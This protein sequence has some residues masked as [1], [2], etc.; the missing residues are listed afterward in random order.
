MTIVLV[1]GNPETD[2]IWRPMLRELG[3][4][5]VIC[6][7]PPGFGAPVPDRFGA[8]WI[9]YRNWLI[10]ELEQIGH[11]VHLVGHDVGGGHAMNTA[12]A[13]PD[14]LLSWTIDVMGAY[15][16]DY[17]WHDLAQLWRTINVGEEAILEWLGGTVDDR[18]QANLSLGITEDVAR[19]LAVGQDQTMIRSLL[20]LYRSWPE[21]M[22]KELAVNLPD[23]SVV[24]GLV[25]I[26][27]GDDYVG[28]VEM[29]RR[30]AERAGAT[31]VVELPHGHWWMLENPTLAAETLTNFW[32][33]VPTAGAHV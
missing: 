5:D 28:N 11:P 3:R 27:T 18:V 14:L 29:R 9:E 6:L 21:A 13:R 33:S 30:T 7:S 20:S 1:H 17:V 8:S 25:V 16:P 31:A 22:L 19:D 32:S 2:V 15:D 10:S 23:A 4:D 12:M 26:A 24:P